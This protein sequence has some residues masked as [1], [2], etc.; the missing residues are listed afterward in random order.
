M[1][2]FCSV[3][4]FGHEKSTV[5]AHSA[6]ILDEVS[7]SPHNEVIPSFGQCLHV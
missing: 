1:T 2:L 3:I 4:V 5:F 6:E 7:M